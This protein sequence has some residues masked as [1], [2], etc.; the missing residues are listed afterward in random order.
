MNEIDFEAR[1]RADGYMEIETKNL[2]LV[3]RKF[4]KA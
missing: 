4:A 1:L 3:G 2:E